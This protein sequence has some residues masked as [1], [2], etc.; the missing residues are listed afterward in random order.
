MTN[1]QDDL[2]EKRRSDGH[3][4]VDLEG[5]DGWKKLVLEADSMLSFI[6]P[7]YKIQQV[8][9]KFGGLRFYFGTEKSGVEYSIMYAITE[10]IESRSRFV[11]EHCG[12]FGRLKEDRK[13]IM[14]LCNSCDELITE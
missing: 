11:C 5:S 8:K 9:Q 4:G 7:D 1:W 14:T 12:E 6:D 10:Y 2:N 3:Y 13:W